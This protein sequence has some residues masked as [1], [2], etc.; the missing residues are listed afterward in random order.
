[1]DALRG[2]ISAFL[3]QTRQDWQML[4]IHDGP[5]PEFIWHMQSYKSDRRIEWMQTE[6]HYADHGH[7][8]RAIALNEPKLNTEWLLWTN[9][10]N[11]YV[12]TFLEWMLGAGEDHDLDL[13]M[14]DMLHDHREYQVL[15]AKLK[16]GHIDVG[17]FIVRV[18]LAK[19]IGFNHRD[20]AADWHFLEELLEE[21]ISVGKMP[22]VLFVHN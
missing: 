18:E 22:A 9:D 7:S 15:P 10:D 19:R 20:Y 3:C 14:C 16:R 21:D 17:A 8:L 4:V 13:V 11:Y 5:N 12:P 2:L 1:M 6:D